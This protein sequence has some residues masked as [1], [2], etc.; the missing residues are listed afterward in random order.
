MHSPETEQRKEAAHAEATRV[1][2]E[3]E[4]RKTAE[5]AARV[6][7]TR[8]AEEEEARK[9]AEIA[10]RVEALREVS[11]IALSRVLATEEAVR[12]EAA[13]VE[14][15]RVEA[16]R[17]EAAHVKAALE[18]AAR[19]EAVRVESAR[20]EAVRVEAARVAT[21][22]AARVE[23]VRVAAEEAARIAKE[24][25]D[26]WLSL[27]E[28]YRRHL[29]KK[30]LRRNPN[31]WPEEIARRIKFREQGRSDA[32]EIAKALV[33]EG[34]S[35]SDEIR[36]FVS[37]GKA[38]ETNALTRSQFKLFKRIKKQ[39]RLILTTIESEKADCD[40]REKFKSIVKVLESPSTSISEIISNLRSLQSNNEREDI[41]RG[42]LP[43]ALA[44]LT[45]EAVI[46]V[47]SNDNL[48]C[49][50]CY[51]TTQ[52]KNVYGLASLTEQLQLI[53]DGHESWHV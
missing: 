45:S 50:C 7:A 10:A 26:R 35:S 48:Y 32:N 17:I 19:V 44:L 51:G 52:C 39:V 8:V 30:F 9:K 4:A 38:D 46:E 37:E 13:R 14:A 16:A 5:T 28:K 53:C 40:Y 41:M 6:E 22:E 21:E 29:E 2:E 23:A 12:V 31:K 25:S 11:R 42:V 3:E 15:A 24:K 1:A 18:E 43:F 33:S 49:G 36:A 20:V 47:V 34:K 27:P